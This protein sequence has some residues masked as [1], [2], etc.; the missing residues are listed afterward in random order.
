EAASAE[1][2][3]QVLSSVSGIDFVI[4]DHAMPGMTGT[5]LAECIRRTWPGVPVVLASGYP[6]VPGDELGLPR[7]SKPYRQ[8]ELARLLASMVGAQIG[9]ASCRATRAIAWASVAAM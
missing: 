6:E 9:R 3:L 2:A 1:I 4:T 7:L 5:D 8:E